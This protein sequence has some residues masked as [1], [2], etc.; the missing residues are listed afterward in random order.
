MKNSTNYLQIYK[1]DVNHVLMI[2]LQLI[3]H[4]SEYTPSAG[5]AVQTRATVVVCGVDVKVRHG[6]Q[7]ILQTAHMTF[8]C[9]H[10]VRHHPKTASPTT[11]TQ[12]CHITT[13]SQPFVAINYLAAHLLLCFIIQTCS[14]Q[15][16]VPKA[17]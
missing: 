2:T 6:A 9:R 16:C 8:K 14:D 10:V 13:F 12:S 17:C 7:Q 5:T 1:S 11:H 15:H 4:S 3:E